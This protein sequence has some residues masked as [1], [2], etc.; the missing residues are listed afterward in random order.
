MGLR[1][2][3]GAIHLREACLLCQGYGGQDGGQVGEQRPTNAPPSLLPRSFLQLFKCFCYTL[4]AMK[5]LSYIAKRRTRPTTDLNG[6][7][8]ELAALVILFE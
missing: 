2:C 1:P 5:T 8:H 6:A 4:I 3:R 7:L